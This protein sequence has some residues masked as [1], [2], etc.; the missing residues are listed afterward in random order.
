MIFENAVKK[1]GSVITNHVPQIINLVPN[2]ADHSF[3]LP[4]EMQMGAWISDA[5]PQLF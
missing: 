5:L 2:M 4:K 1:V 3:V